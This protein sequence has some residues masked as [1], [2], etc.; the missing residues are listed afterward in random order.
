M[1]KAGWN[2]IHDSSQ[3]SARLTAMRQTT[4][5]SNQADTTQFEGHHIRIYFKYQPL[6]SF[7]NQ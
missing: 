1:T 7:R 4:V 5:P 3:V 2:T 6:I